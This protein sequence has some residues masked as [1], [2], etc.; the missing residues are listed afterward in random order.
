M[1]HCLQSSRPQTSW[2]QRVDSYLPHQE[3]I[4]TK[5]TSWSRPL[6]A[7]IIKLV[8]IFPRLGYLVLGVISM[9]CPP[10]PDQAI[11]LS[12]ST[13]SK[14]LSPR[15]DSATVYREAELEA[16]PSPNKDAMEES[17]QS[18][19]ESPSHS[20]RML[21]HNDTRDQGRLG[22][23]P[24]CMLTSVHT[25]KDCRDKE[26]GNQHPAPIF[27]RQGAWAQQGRV[28]PCHPPAQGSFSASYGPTL[29]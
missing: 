15:F 3:P 2:T 4:R 14:T 29:S 23:W 11:K 19:K 16:S 8:T 28:L 22:S 6:W 1:V 12:F 21:G 18:E 10:L 17:A 5:S 9:L 13:S 24:P 26:T 7:T 20:S 27:Y 25:R